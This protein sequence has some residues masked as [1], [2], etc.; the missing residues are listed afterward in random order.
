MIDSGLENEHRREQG[1]V[2]T[3][4]LRMI[5]AELTRG[6]V[7]EG[8]RYAKA[9]G[10]FQE[11]LNNFAVNGGLNGISLVDAKGEAFL[12]SINSP[13]LP[14]PVLAKVEALYRTG[15]E[16]SILHLLESGMIGY[17]RV[18][19]I[20]SIQP[21]VGK[22]E[23]E[24]IA[25]LVTFKLS[26]EW[27]AD[28]LDPGE[29]V[30]Y[31]QAFYLLT[32]NSVYTKAG[33]Q[34]QS[35][36]PVGMSFSR[37]RSLKG[38]DEAVYTLSRHLTAADWTLTIEVAASIVDRPLFGYKLTGM[39]VGGLLLLLIGGGMVLLRN[40]QGR[41]FQAAMTE[42]YRVAAEKVEAQRRFLDGINGAL[43]DL[44][45][46]KNRKGRYIYVNPAMVEALHKP[47]QEILGQGDRKLFSGKI[48]QRLSELGDAA[49]Q[50]GSTV[51]DSEVISMEGGERYYLFGA[52][53]LNH[54]DDAGG[55]L[56][57]TAKDVTE[58]H[59]LQLEKERLA[60][61]TIAALVATIEKKDPYLKGQTACTSQLATGV[62]NIL[63]LSSVQRRSL[64]QAAQLSQ[65]GK[66]FI[67]QE[68]S[69][70]SERLDSD[71]LAEVRQHISQA[72]EAL[73][74]LGLAEGTMNALK[75][76]Y[77][78]LDGSGFPRGVSGE[79][80]DRLGRVL[81][82]AD[83][84]T[85]RALPRSNRNPIEAEEAVKVLQE[86]PARYDSEIVDAVRNYLNSAAGAEFI[87]QIRRESSA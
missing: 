74:P 72:V 66:S 42:H 71:E 70:R 16:G 87:D 34:L 52:V 62:G 61:N 15:E 26:G 53:P 12:S 73:E 38:D 81:G 55:G 25:V 6:S 57:V 27:L 8:G 68:L 13:V 46:V 19:A 32:E 51:R 50:Q 33:E 58:L 67:P 21:A 80:V 4:S 41:E 85:A 9:I 36:R 30:L 78:R 49:Y 64:H 76:M 37:E 79:G 22:D 31:D 18:T 44:I 63:G 84:I 82:I 3:P 23:P 54:G 45:G 77:E 59:K 69:T 39:V 14:S 40:R 86:H 48:T 60:D 35:E 10:R 11:L 43:P 24:V 65:I 75:D 5:A 28:S 83:I 56:I 47:K 17:F 2:E 29:G 1:F 7:S 20:R